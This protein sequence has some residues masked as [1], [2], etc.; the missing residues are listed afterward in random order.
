M[1]IGVVNKLRILRE[2]NIGLFLG[3]DLGQDVLLPNK[4]CPLSYKINDEIEV[5]VYL[6]NLGRKIATNLI[7]KIKLYEFALLKVTDVTL[8]GAFVDWGI[9]KELLVPFREQKQKMEK[10]RWYIVYLDIDKKTERLY[11]TNRLER[12][13]QNKKLTVKESEQVDLIVIR[14]TELGY[15]AIINNKHSGLIYENETYKS[16]NIGEKIVGYIKKI[17]E[18]NKIDLSVKPLI[19]YNFIDKN[20]EIIYKAL[21]KNS[22][23]LPYNDDSSP[24]EIAKVFGISKKAFKKAVGSLYKERKITIDID[25]IRIF[26]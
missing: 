2:T 22:G 6:D 12:H 26:E 5:F 21:L 18:D 7:P 13:F 9:E 11:A 17:R 8:V 10:G 14:K 19:S 4:Y 1:R 3:D 20:S 15:V 25:G 23:F 16:L 24:L